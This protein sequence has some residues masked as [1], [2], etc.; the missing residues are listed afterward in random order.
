MMNN[1]RE[2]SLRV[3]GG[4]RAGTAEAGDDH[5][6]ESE[7]KQCGIHDNRSWTRGMFVQQT[8]LETVCR[9]G[10]TYVLVT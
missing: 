1:S 2:H 5:V 7:R 10:Y 6:N 8:I 4:V 9:R 3:G